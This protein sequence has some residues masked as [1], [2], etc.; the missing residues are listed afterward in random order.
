MAKET[1]VR[2]INALNEED[3]TTARSLLQDDFS[4][5]GVL[6]ARDGADV[7]IEE[8]KQMKLKYDVQKVLE[9]GDDVAVFYNIL[10][11][12]KRIFSSGW[13]QLE[14]GRIRH[15]KVLFDPR[16]LLN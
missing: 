3:F 11:G 6:G 9:D 14:N 7:Y 5:V 2:F 15:F 16:P 13:Y 4:F 10:I 12:G 8:M 1:V